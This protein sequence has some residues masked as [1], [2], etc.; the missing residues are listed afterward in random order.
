MRPLRLKLKAFTS[1]RDEQE[2]DFS[3]LD[4]FAIAGPTGAGKSS[5]LDAMTYALYGRVERVGDRVAQLISQ[6][7]PAMAVELEFA[8]DAQRY[9]LTRRTQRP[10]PKQAALTKAI[11][12]R[13]EADEWV[14]EA[15][16][17]REVEARVRALVGLDY[18]GFT[19]AVLLP[20][21]KFDQFLTGDAPM[22]RRILSDLLGLELWQRMAQHANGIA[23]AAR[24]EREQTLRFLS[25]DYAD[26]SKEALAEQRKHAKELRAREKELVAVQEKVR[27]IQQRRNEA[28]RQAADLRACADE[29]RQIASSTLVVAK[30]MKEAVVLCARAARALEQAEEGVSDATSK[31]NGAKAAHDSAVKKWGSARA[32]LALRGKAERYV[33]LRDEHSKLKKGDICPTCGRVLTETPKPAP[34]TAKRMAALEE[35]IRSALGKLPRDPVTA[36]EERASALEDLEDVARATADAASQCERE[37]TSAQTGVVRA[38]GRVREEHA[39]LPLAALRALAARAVALAPSSKFPRLPQ[40]PPAADA[41]DELPTFAAELAETARTVAAA[42]DAASPAEAEVTYLSDAM[43][44]VGDLVPAARD[45]DALATSVDRAV[46]EAAGEAKA[47][48]ERSADIVKRLEKK[49][50]LEAEVKQ[51]EARE[52]VMH[53]LALDLKQDAIVDFVQAEALHALAAEGSKRL[54]YLS[55]GRYRLRFRDD[56]FFV[57]DGNNGDEERS[58]RT[59]SGGESFL[60]S[61]ALALTLSE[62]VRALA[63]TQHA[64]LDSLFLDEGFGTLDPE[65]LQTVIEGIERLGVDD[66]LVGVISHV[67]ELTDQFRR[68]EVEKLPRGSRIRLAA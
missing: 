37:R 61:L 59:L 34:A 4:L 65:T 68:I 23:S 38:E 48:E 1:F 50:Q 46:R 63:T 17:V 26:V 39:K 62:Q 66:R 9:L 12:Q 24:R 2:V 18:E 10:T 6:G 60:A 64:R 54:R 45:L 35:A 28:R 57:A 40:H 32:V 15:G 53:A 27:A 43:K 13:L 49:A 25:D 52:H 16:Q 31:A 58:V 51:L 8:I 55:S 36:L 56:E 44:A 42:L 14:D 33:E 21:G 67:R 11:L 19:R 7:L 30:A 47:A 5:L 22:R 41:L 29:A 20:Q 3:Q